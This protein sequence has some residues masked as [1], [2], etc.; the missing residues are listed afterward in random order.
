MLACLFSADGA[1]GIGSEE[2]MVSFCPL[3][4]FGSWENFDSDFEVDWF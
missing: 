1:F 2:E 4:D 3:S